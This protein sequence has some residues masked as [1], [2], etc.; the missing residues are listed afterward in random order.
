MRKSH[1]YASIRMRIRMRMQISQ[2]HLTLNARRS[3]PFRSAARARQR[4]TQRSATT[5]LHVWRNAAIV[6]RSAA[7]AAAAACQRSKRCVN[8]AFENT[9]DTVL[10]NASLV[11]TCDITAP[12]RLSPRASVRIVYRYCIIFMLYIIYTVCNICTM[13]AIYIYTS[14][15]ICITSGTLKKTHSHNSLTFFFF[16]F[17]PLLFFLVSI[18]LT[19]GTLCILDIHTTMYYICYCILLYTC[20]YYYICALILA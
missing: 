1:T 11:C 19:A 16:L 18:C 9:L 17:F 12:H 15:Y 14:H 7:L 8:A 13:Y 20:I 5:L 6:R 10:A 4:P 3:T 2:G